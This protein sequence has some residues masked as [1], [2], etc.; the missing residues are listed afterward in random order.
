MKTR[1]NA[2]ATSTT[3]AIDQILLVMISNG[4]TGITSRCS[5]V[6]CSRSRINAAPVSTIESIVTWLTTSMTAP[7]QDL[8][9]SGLKRALR[10]RSTGSV[11]AAAIT[12]C[13][14]VDLSSNYGMDIATTSER[15][16]HTG[17][18]HVELDRR[19]PPRQDVALEVGRNVQREGVKPCIHPCIH[20]GSG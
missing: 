18:I 19:T 10:T 17:R 11:A 1:A 12:L 9:S 7:N 14:S 5:I 6:P 15:L 4:V 2:Q 8:L 3:S 16:T 20:L 13:E